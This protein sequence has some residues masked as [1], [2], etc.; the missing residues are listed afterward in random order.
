MGSCP[1]GPS[2]PTWLRSQKAVEF[3]DFSNAS[4]SDSV[5]Y[6][7]WDEISSNLSLLNVSFNQLKGHPPSTLNI[8]PFADVDLS[9]NL[10]EG[11][12]PLPIVEVE[13]LD[14]SNN[15]LSGPIPAN[16]FDSLPNTIF[17]ALS[18]PDNRR[19]PSFNWQ[20][21]MASSHRSVK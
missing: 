20:H 10:F 5:P 19:N 16:I 14:L 9:F 1:L 13:L 2:F 8:S 18:G 7:F 21:G 3:L 11:S 17:L 15:E 6:W 4:I 12:I